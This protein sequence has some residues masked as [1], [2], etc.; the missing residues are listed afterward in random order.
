MHR[1][2]ALEVH[3][4]AI[5]HVEGSGLHGEDVQHI[6]VVQLAVADVDERGN[7][8]AQVQQGVQL[9]GGLGRSKRRPFE[10]AQARESMV[11]ASSA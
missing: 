9:D 8:P 1:V 5:H 2:Q 6:D 11:V 7:R 3:V 10:Q 4:A